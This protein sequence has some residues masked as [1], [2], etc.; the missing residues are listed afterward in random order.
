MTKTISGTTQVWQIGDNKARKYVNLQTTYGNLRKLCK[1]EVYD[2]KN[3]EQRPVNKPWATTLKKEMISGKFVP[4]AFYASVINDEDVTYTTTDRGT[5]ADIR[6][7][8][9]VLALTDG[10][11]RNNVLE[12]LRGTYVSER[13][14]DNLPV[15]MMVNLEAENRVH[16]FLKYN[17]GREVNA[18]HMLNLKIDTGDIGDPEVHEMAR[19]MANEL[20]E[21]INS[22]LN[23]S[24]DILGGG[25]APLTLKVAINSH[26]SEQPMSLYGTALICR[27][28][29]KDVDWGVSQVVEAWQILS[30]MNPELVKAGGSLCPPPAGK[31]RPANMIIGMANALAYRLFLLKEEKCSD[32]EVGL[33][34]AA[35]STV[36]GGVDNLGN[37]ET[38]RILLGNF[39]DELL[40]DVRDEAETGERE[41]FTG[42][43]DGLPIS[44]G[45]LFS[46]AAFGRES[47]PKPLKTKKT[48]E[49]KK[50][51]IIE[52]TGPIEIES[53]D[54]QGSE[55]DT[56]DDFLYNDGPED[57]FN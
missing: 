46:M 19:S 18:T 28:Y 51:V 37:S 41:L 53:L 23:N 45:Q 5:K 54:T 14:I 13:I 8:N 16:D 42:F 4:A 9:G 52:S 38:Q 24:I 44:L 57:I 39:V 11:H 3:G 15:T 30:E 36:F 26:K 31:K 29:E 12:S 43:H 49:V 20:N 56:T 10:S 48:K 25:S 47:L 32:E 35:A 21:H 1:V 40:T 50:L 17:A 33:F 55:S 34:S 22:H 2:G 7:D 27:Q 6:F